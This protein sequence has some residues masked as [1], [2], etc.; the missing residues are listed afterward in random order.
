MHIVGWATDARG[1]R[2]FITKNSWG[3]D[4]SPGSKLFSISGHLIRDTV[5]ALRRGGPL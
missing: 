1:T 5:A 2:Y 3:T 4:R